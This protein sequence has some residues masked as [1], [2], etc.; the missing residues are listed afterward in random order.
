MGFWQL[1]ITNLKITY[2]NRSGLFWT[3]I[4]PVVIYSTVSVLPIPNIGAAGYSYPDFVLSG[5][6]AMVIMQG[7]I[8]TL[9]YWMID[10]KARGVIKRFQVTPLRKID[11]IMSL[12]L[13]R[14]TVVLIQI[15]LLTIVGRIFFDA[16]L[17]GNPVWIIIFGIL[18]AFAFLPIGLLI[19]TWADTYESAAPITAAIGLPMMFL[20]NIFY[21]TSSLPDSLEIVSKFLPITYLADGLRSVYL[22]EYSSNMLWDAVVLIGWI[23]FILIV[24]MKRFK[25][26]E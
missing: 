19:S 11:L 17:S 12:M 20:G 13:A 7:G 3:V 5:I 24:T 25:F 1:F 18:G 23:I 2:R 21:P 4:I 22:Y 10:L 15:I 16:T 9:A 6:I 8:Y 14:S 26:R